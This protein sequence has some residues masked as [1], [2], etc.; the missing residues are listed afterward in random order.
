MPEISRFLW[1]VICMYFTDH[2]PPHFHAKYNDKESLVAIK[3]LAVLQWNLP[4]KVLALVIERAS[5]H[6]KELLEDR[7]LASSGKQVQLKKI[8]PLV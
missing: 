1:I 7:E 6:Q 5:Q 2:N 3:D 4:P 8:K